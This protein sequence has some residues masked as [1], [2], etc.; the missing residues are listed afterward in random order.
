MTMTINGSGTIVG[1]NAGGLPDATVT[2]SDLESGAA[3]GNLG[4]TPVDESSILGQVAWFAK[5]TAPTGWLKANGATISR[6]TY[7]ALFAAIGTTFGAGDG[8]TTFTIPDLRGEFI[9][10]WDD[11]R[12]I[13]SGRS[14]GTAQSDSFQG[15]AHE[16]GTVNRSD[17]DDGFSNLHVTFATPSRGVGTVAQSTVAQQPIAHSTYGSVRLANETRARNV[18]LLACIKY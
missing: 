6:S 16:I 10:G 12:G 14:F 1:L 4:F 17:S 15:H 2:A 9:R 13:D 3:V 11:S 18:A 7:A 8:S 5:N